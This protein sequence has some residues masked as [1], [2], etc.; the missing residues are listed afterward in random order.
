MWVYMAIGSAIMLGLYDVAKKQSL[1]RND[2]LVVLALATGFSALF[3]CPWLSRG[4]MHQHLCLWIKTI[5]VTTSWIS[6]MEALKL[7][8]LT[9]ASTIK[10]S[11]P[12]FVL[13]FSV[14]LFG[15]K[16][17]GWQW[18][19][20]IIAIASLYLLSISSKKE[21]IEFAH[22]KGIAQMAVSVITG[23][24]SAL[25]DKHI[26]GS[27]EP[28][29]V[30]SWANLYI[31]LLLVAIIAFKKMRGGSANDGKP[32]RWDWT[33]LLIAIAITMADA[34]YFFSLKADGALLAVISMIR[35]S[36]VIV[37]F[38]LGALLFKEGNLKAKSLD[39]VILLVAMA[40]IIIGSR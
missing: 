8:P 18:A 1:K 3:L 20:S 11:R 30:Q 6:G 17:N 5:L 28:L 7:L 4:T 14:I 19:G 33:I 12:V 29:F 13:L 21:G 23:V 27:M 25:Y 36:S 31:T 26:M 32:F 38:A 10:A 15:E 9:T 22:N 39:L 35:R 24:A 2:T 16:L 40:L 37:T 34:L